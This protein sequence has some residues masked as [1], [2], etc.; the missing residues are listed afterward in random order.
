METQENSDTEMPQS[1]TSTSNLETKTVAKNP[2][3][4][5]IIPH[6]I[7]LSLV[8]E[9]IL[10]HSIWNLLFIL[11]W[12]F[13]GISIQRNKTVLVSMHRLLLILFVIIN[14]PDLVKHTRELIIVMPE[15]IL[16]LKTL[17]IVLQQLMHLYLLLF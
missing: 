3:W 17:T 7:I 1:E 6:Y 8:I 12:I 14:T 2:W 9:Q 4:V 13:I 10:Y 5:K 11:A 16:R 15:L